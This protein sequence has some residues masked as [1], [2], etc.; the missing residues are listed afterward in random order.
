MPW[1]I[2][3]NVV[4]K[5]LIASSKCFRRS[6][7]VS[8][9]PIKKSS[10]TKGEKPK[11]KKSG[12]PFSNSFSFQL[13]IIVGAMGAGYSLG[14]SFVTENAPANLF[15]AGST[16]AISKIKKADKSSEYGGYDKFKRCILRILESQ[17][18]EIDQKNYDNKALYDNP[19][20]SKDI[21]DV[22]NCGESIQEVFFGK[23][24][25]N[26]QQKEYVFYPESAEQVSA[27]L[28]NC[29]EFHIPVFT[30]SD[31]YISSLKSTGGYRLKIDFS[32]LNKID[33]VDQHTVK[34]QIGAK[35][36]ALRDRMNNMDCDTLSNLNSLTILCSLLGI[37]LPCT[38]SRLLCNKIDKSLIEGVTA[39]LPDGTI[40]KVNRFSKD[41]NENRA[42]NLLLS[43]EPNCCI[44]T[45]AIITRKKESAFSL[46][47]L[48]F[49]SLLSVDDMV[50]K[51]KSI[52]PDI[53]ISFIDS[54]KCPQI[55]SAF[56]A[57]RTLCVFKL[58]KGNYSKLGSIFDDKSDEFKTF[59]FDSKDFIS[60][61][62]FHYYSNLLSS[63]SNRNRKAT[64]ALIVSPN[65]VRQDP[66]TFY[67][68][69]MMEETTLLD[70]TKNGV[71]VK[72]DLFRRI[73]FSLDP[74]RV[75]NP[76]VEIQLEPS[77]DKE[78]RK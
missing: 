37:Q 4:Q 2:L 73:K 9:R 57:Y 59:K 58:S 38:K 68:M 61:N 45:D 71:D 66:E 69:G 1:P 17:K 43:Y 52:I 18:L 7:S 16:T 51:I 34:I 3:N 22:M 64:S 74:A 67:S 30:S 77:D 63:Q 6:V 46:Y 54:V 48:G 70:S 33:K 40:E 49:K 32:R 75:L 25:K 62:E 12:S 13:F 5:T 10:I 42:F 35:P 39:V 14:K 21:S 60:S 36:T 56:G 31:A 76:N 55:Q 20:I 23:K 78:A 11:E 41:P 28:K 50:N 53:D 29:Q 15:P 47:I 19:F 26:L 24:V 72:R 65:I 8:G 44:I 27:I